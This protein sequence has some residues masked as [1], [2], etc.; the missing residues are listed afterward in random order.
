MTRRSSPTIDQLVVATFALL[1]VGLGARPIGDNSAFTHLRTGIDMVAHGLIPAIPRTDPYSFTAYGDP[2]VVQSWLASAGVGW[3]HRLGGGGAVIVLNAITMGALAWLIAW[4]ARTGRPATTVAAAFGALAIGFP[5]WAPR[6]LLVGLLCLGLTILVVERRRSPW[7]LLPIVWVWVS[8]HGSFPLGLA[9]LGATC[10]GAWFDQRSRIERAT[11]G[12]PWRYLG[13]FVGG[14]ALGAVNPLG[15]RLLSFA[16][17]ALAKRDVFANIVEWQPADFQSQEGLVCLA[18]IVVSVL[19]V[20]RHRVGWR[21]L[22]PTAGFL[23]LGLLA[24]RNLAPLGIVM[25]PTLAAAFRSDAPVMSSA[26]SL[27]RAI[28]GF[29]AAVALVLVLSGVNGPTLRVGAY[30]VDSIDWLQA[31]G[32]FAPGRH[33]ITP[34]HVGN[35]IELHLGLERA[36]FID[37]RVD[38]FSTQVS[39]D[40]IALLHD[41][42][43]ALDVL[44][45]WKA[46]TVL[47]TRDSSLV[48]RMLATRE[49]R[50]VHRE[51]RWVVLEPSSP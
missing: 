48:R 42:Q 45:K 25:A 16:A 22:L 18:G 37:D 33:V 2:W 5:F 7:W 20:A 36:V 12:P 38:M 6:P 15:P 35:Y 8:S 11:E 34:D 50:I 14:L 41:E 46:D 24:Q 28:A 27:N 21:Y 47:W 26:F 3:A 40:Y 9:W 23:G 17:S 49:W 43:R 44:D 19:I 51:P 31:Q 32:R 4:L 1:G 10:V 29:L 30:P 39:K 13:F